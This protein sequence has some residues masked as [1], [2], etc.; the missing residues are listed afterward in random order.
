LVSDDEHGDRGGLDQV[1][2]NAVEEQSAGAAAVVLA[3][4]DQIESVLVGVL[5]EC[6]GVLSRVSTARKEPSA[7]VRRWAVR[8]PKLPPGLHLATN[9]IAQPGRPSRL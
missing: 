8:E 2:G 4:E 1:L 5:Q 3:A 9:N 6:A 7:L